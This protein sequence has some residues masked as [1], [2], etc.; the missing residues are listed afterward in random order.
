MNRENPSSIQAFFLTCL[1]QQLSKQRCWSSVAVRVEGYEYSDTCTQVSVC[2]LMDCKG[3]GSPR[4]PPHWDPGLRRGRGSARGPQTPTQDSRL[5]KSAR[6]A[7][8]ISHR[9]PDWQNWQN[10]HRGPQC[11]RTGG[12][13]IS[14]N[15]GFSPARRVLPLLLKLAGRA[16]IG[17]LQVQAPPPSHQGSCMSKVQ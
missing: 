13:M 12:Y 1:V 9:E 14:G 8:L 10:R 4:S 6:Q 16:L 7:I 3:R 15:A 17:H 2:V 11:Q 5:K